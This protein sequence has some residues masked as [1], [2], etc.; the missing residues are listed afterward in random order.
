MEATVS[1]SQ[2]NATQRFVMKTF[3]TAKNEQEREELTSFYLDYIQQ[4]LDKAANE[5]WDAQNLDNTK[6][7]ELMYGHLR[8]SKK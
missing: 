4:K 5:F 2:L 6:M 7:E 3:A 8:S 1:H